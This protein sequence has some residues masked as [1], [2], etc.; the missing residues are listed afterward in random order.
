MKC[1]NCDIDNTY[2]D[3][4]KNIGRCKN[5]RHEFVFEPYRFMKRKFTDSFFA[6]LITDISANDTLLFTP[7][8]LYYLLNK[9][10]RSRDRKSDK[11]NGSK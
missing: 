3:R 7:R 5:C 2:K 6:N 9:R 4:T 11:L 10:L 1:I 8:Q